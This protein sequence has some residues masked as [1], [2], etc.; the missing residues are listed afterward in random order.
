MSIFR[1]INGA[2]VLKLWN[3]M[4]WFLQYIDKTRIYN[5]FYTERAESI[6]FSFTVFRYPFSQ[7]RFLGKEIFIITN[8]FCRMAKPDWRSLT[9]DIFAIYLC[10]SRIFFS[11][12]RNLITRALI[13]HHW[14]MRY[15]QIKRFFKFKNSFWDSNNFNIKLES[16]F[17]FLKVT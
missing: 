16:S 12:P 5:D 7:E 6:T 8:R 14:L 10:I 3:L 4:G 15:W 9:F 17:L 11:I 2:A 13:L 1:W